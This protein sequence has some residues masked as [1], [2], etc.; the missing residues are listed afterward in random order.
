LQVTPEEALAHTKTQLLRLLSDELDPSR[1]AAIVVEPIQGE[2]GYVI[3]PDGFLPWLA[4]L[5]RQHGILLAADEV[6]SGMG[7]TG[8]WFAHQHAHVRPDIIIM[9]KALGGGLPLSAMTARRD[10]M[11]AWTP[12][13]HGTTFGGNP[14]ACAT[15]LAQLHVMKAERLVERAQQLGR[16]ALNRLQAANAWPAVVDVRGRGLM[17]ALEFR[18]DIGGS[19]VTSVMQEGLRRGLI[20]HPA[21]LNHEVIRLMPPLNIDETVFDEGLSELLDIVQGLTRSLS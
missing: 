10:L 19:L 1:V 21:G 17:V 3:P 15:G 12:G 16:Q 8:Q 4:E 20:I 11:Q 7:R 6:Q 5:C 14:L 9:G 2:G 18:R 13:T